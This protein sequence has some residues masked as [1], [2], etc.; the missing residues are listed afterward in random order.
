MV[1]ILQALLA[2]RAGVTVSNASSQTKGGNSVA[3][4]TAEDQDNDFEFDGTNV[5]VWQYE[6]VECGSD[7]WLSPS[8][9]SSGWAVSDDFRV[10]SDGSVIFNDDADNGEFEAGDWVMLAIQATDDGSVKSDY[11]MMD[12]EF[13]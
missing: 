9:N 13:V 8:G 7:G 11:Y 4:L 6:I 12:V 5:T 10:A 1:N 3:T 2:Q